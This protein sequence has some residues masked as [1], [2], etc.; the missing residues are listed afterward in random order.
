MVDREAVWDIL[1][2]EINGNPGDFDRAT[3]AVLALLNGSTS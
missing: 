3:D 2:R 1:D